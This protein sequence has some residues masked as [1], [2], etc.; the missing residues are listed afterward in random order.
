MHTNEIVFVNIKFVLE[1][2]K[3]ILTISNVCVIRPL[4]A[5]NNVV[6]H[7]IFKRMFDTVVNGVT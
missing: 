2:W 3:T 7:V 1:F 6:L 4:S 5:L